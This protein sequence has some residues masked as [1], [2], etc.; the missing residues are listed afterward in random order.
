MRIVGGTKRF[1]VCIKQGWPSTNSQHPTMEF[2]EVYSDVG[3]GMHI[4]QCKNENSRG[5]ETSKLQILWI[6]HGW[7][8]AHQGVQWSLLQCRLA[9][10]PVLSCRHIPICH[11]FSELSCHDCQAEASYSLV[12]RGS[13]NISLR[14]KLG[15]H[16]YK[17]TR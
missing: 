7:S 3:I 2:H 1:F 10:N 16:N 11:I 9:I 14:F 4:N 13:R 6:T 8:T 12:K 15:Y 17:F 5:L